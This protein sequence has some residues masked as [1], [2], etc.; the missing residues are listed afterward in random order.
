MELHDGRFLIPLAKTDTFLSIVFTP[1]TLSLI[2]IDRTRTIALI[3]ADRPHDSVIPYIKS[4]NY[5]GCESGECGEHR[6]DIIILGEGFDPS[7]IES[8]EWIG[9]VFFP[10]GIT[11]GMVIAWWN[12]RRRGCI[13]VGSLMVFYIVHFAASGSFP[14]GWAWVV[15]ASPGILFLMHGILT[16]SENIRIN[17]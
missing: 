1:H 11:T 14:Q 12:E 5:L 3:Y 2:L 7:K 17:E 4:G 10:F 13:T 9:L 8:T 6:N 15:F 16:P